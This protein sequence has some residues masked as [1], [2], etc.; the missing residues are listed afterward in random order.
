M[1]LILARKIRQ[2]RSIV[3]ILQQTIIQKVS[4]GFRARNRSATHR[5]SI[6]KNDDELQHIFQPDRRC[7]YPS[8]VIIKPQLEKKRIRHHPYRVYSWW[9]VLPSQCAGNID[10]VKKYPVFVHTRLL[11]PHRV[12]NGVEGFVI[13][14][15]SWRTQDNA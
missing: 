14:C 11:C 2:Y 3:S 7:W 6:S 10:I 5:R 1:A 13:S 15:L 12:M 9:A 8:S 4:L